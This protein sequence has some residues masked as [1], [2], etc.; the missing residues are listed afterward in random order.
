MNL[1]LPQTMVHY[2]SK[3]SAAVGYSVKITQQLKLIAAPMNCIVAYFNYMG[4][5][6]LA[7]FVW[8]I[9]V[10]QSVGKRGDGLHQTTIQGTPETSVEFGLG[11]NSLGPRPSSW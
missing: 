5:T 1:P 6:L 11:G 9:F 3:I 2:V 4:C 10:R 7:T 8:I